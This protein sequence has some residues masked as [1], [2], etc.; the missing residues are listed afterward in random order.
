M[1]NLT[2]PFLDLK[3]EDI[4]DDMD[5]VQ[6]WS[7][8]L[9]D[10]LKS[11]LCNLDSGNVMEAGSVKAQ[12]I[13]CTKARIKGAQIQSL[14]ADKLTAGTIDAEVITV[15]GKSDSGKMT[16]SGEKLEFW[17]KNSNQPRIYIGRSDNSYIFIVQSSDG[18]Q[19]VYMDSDGRI[20]ITGDIVGGKITSNAVIEVKEDVNVGKKITLRDR[21][22][23]TTGY[24]KAAIISVDTDNTL[25]IQAENNRG[26][27][28]ETDGNIDLKCG[29]CRVN[30]KVIVTQE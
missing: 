3:G 4:N 15:E 10:E 22:E 26:I 16:M 14:T 17:E 30:G 1:P 20:S 19:G 25:R 9:I 12:N 11:I 23:N 29:E 13:D 24:S 8:S 21:N 18:K 5:K 2:T 7:V 28:I 27:V 6:Q